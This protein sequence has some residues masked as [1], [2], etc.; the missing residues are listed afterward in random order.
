MAIGI[1]IPLKITI[2]GTVLSQA[3]NIVTWYTTDGAAFLTADPAQVGE[4]YWNDIKGVWRALMP[5]SAGM[6][7]SLV[8]VAEAGS[9]GAYG[10]YAI[11]PGEQ[12]GLRSAAGSDFNPSFMA[13]GIKQTVATRTTRPGQKRIPG[14]LEE[15]GGANVWTSA[16]MTLL[17]NLAPKF[18]AP[19]VL[20][21]PVATG[22]LEPIV[23]RLSPDGSTVL[24][25]QPVTGFVVN[26]NQTTQNSRKV[27][28]GI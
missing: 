7:T 16:Y 26:P 3:F 13:A 8:R 28:R 4:A 24:A 10:E 15:D 5:N 20:G 25:S 23:A 12:L 2:V 9:T 17:N 21:A 19:I 22:G 14:S 11:P 27:G 1:G 6:R 18:A